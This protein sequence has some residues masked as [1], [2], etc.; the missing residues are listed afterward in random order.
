[1]PPRHP[2][3]VFL[4]LIGGGGGGGVRG[5]TRTQGII[6]D[7][8]KKAENEKQSSGPETSS[9]IHMEP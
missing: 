6:K 8:E 9:R 4:V 1:M 2:K 3:V 7:G 5:G